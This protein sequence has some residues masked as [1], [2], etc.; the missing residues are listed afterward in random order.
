MSEKQSLAV[1]WAVST[2]R[3][4]PIEVHFTIYTD[5][6]SLRWLM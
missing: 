2:L 1:V 5:Q 6:V 3:P 4:Y